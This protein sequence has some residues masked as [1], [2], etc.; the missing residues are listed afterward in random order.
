MPTVPMVYDPPNDFYI[1]TLLLLN[2]TDEIK[3]KK[4]LM[5]TVLF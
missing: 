1:T 2:W 5:P 4:Q 3:Q